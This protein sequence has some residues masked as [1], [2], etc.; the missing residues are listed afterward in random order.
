MARDFARSFYKSKE[1]ESCRAA[2][3]ASRGYLC[4]DC[5]ARGI[6][7]PGKIVHHIEALTPLNIT[8]PE[9][10]LSFNN[11]RLVCQQCHADEHH[12][13]SERRY[14]IGPDGEIIVPPASSG[15]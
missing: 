5:L 7:T 4:E 3:M 15:E 8:N 9:V 1:W 12:R 2:F 10:T 6:Y 14:E 13:K 11:L